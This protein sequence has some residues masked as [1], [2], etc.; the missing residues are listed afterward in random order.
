MGVMSGGGEIL[1]TMA[2]PCGMSVILSVALDINRN[3]Y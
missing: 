3:L 1:L 2:R